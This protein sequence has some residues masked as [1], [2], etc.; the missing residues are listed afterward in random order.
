M[1]LQ[2][3]SHL[4]AL[5]QWLLYRRHELQTE[6]HAANEARRSEDVGAEPRD[7]KD[8]AET[9]QRQRVDDVQLAR[10]LAELQDVED[11]LGRLDA[12][13]YGDCATC[14]EPIAAARLNVQPAARLCASCQTAVE[15]NATGGV[16][17]GNDAQV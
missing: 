16:S 5:R 14:G 8:E 11:A 7:R 13:T 3:Q 4:P 17:R 12:G 15:R 9:H 2:T 6:V 10:D 1:D